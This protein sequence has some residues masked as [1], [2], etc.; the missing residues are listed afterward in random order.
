MKTAD[1][2]K[3]FG[4][5]KKLA[6]ACKINPAAVSQ[7]GD[8]VPQTQSYKLELLTNGELKVAKEKSSTQPAA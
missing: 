4:S 8:F 7:W 5:K 1:A 3:Y 2:I 6:S